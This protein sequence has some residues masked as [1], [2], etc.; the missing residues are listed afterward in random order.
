MSAERTT[1]PRT[2]RAAIGAGLVVIGLGLAVQAAP[3]LALLNESSSLPKGLYLRAFDQTP[4]QGAV[5]ALDQPP[6]A[7]RYLAKLGM[8][9]HIPLLKRIAAT[10]GEL[11]CR[12]GGKLQWAGRSVTALPRDRRGAP[13]PAWSGCRLLAADELL[14]IG[15]TP[16]SFDS[17]YFGP[18]R[19]ASLTGIYV[20]ALR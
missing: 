3:P 19:R 2:A 13:L 9:P 20:E 6:A 15:D 18:V 5:V 10:G 17:R 11:V 4:R 14:V 8:P 1:A 16:T 12:S 7:R